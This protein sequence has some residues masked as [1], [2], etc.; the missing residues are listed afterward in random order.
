VPAAA[1]KLRKIGKGAATKEGLRKALQA[2]ADAL[3]ETIAAAEA[4]GKLRGTQR[5]PAAFTGYILAH[6][7]HH[8]GQIILHLKYAGTPVDPALGYSTWEWEKISPG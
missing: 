1:K 2:S 4:G 8:R 5:G 6:E 7:V 3:G